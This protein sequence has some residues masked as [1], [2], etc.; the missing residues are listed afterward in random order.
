M[1]KSKN[2]MAETLVMAISEQSRIWGAYFFRNQ[3]ENR[4]LTSR[5]GLLNDKHKISRWEISEIR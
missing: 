3:S 1:R 4:I 5:S 2:D